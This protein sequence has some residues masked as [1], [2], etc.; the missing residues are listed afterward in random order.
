MG[1]AVGAEMTTGASVARGGLWLMLSN[2]LPQ[3]YALVLSIA[4]ARYLGPSGMGRQSFIAFVE[5]ATAEILSSGLAVSLM[6]FVG[7][8]V[9]AGGTGQARW[10]ASRILRVQAGGALIGGGAL[11][12]LGLL[13]HRPQAA[14]ILAGVTTAAA[15]VAAVPGAVLTGLQRWR[16]ATVAGLTT[17]GLGTAATVLVLALGGGIT[18]M[19]A[20][21]AAAGLIALVWT[22]AL[23]RGALTGIGKPSVSAPDLRR[24]A[25]RYAAFVSAGQL[26]NL[27]VWRRSEFFFLDHYSPDRQIAFYS[28][29][30]G[31]VTALVRL[32]SAMG[33]VLAPAVATLFGAGAH[34]RIR[35]GFSRALRLLLLL[36]MPLAAA[37]AAVGP[38]TLRVIWGADYGPTTRPF[39]IM[40]AASL[41]T[42]LTVLGSSLITG[43]GRV[44]LPLLADTGAAAVDIGLAFA[45]VPRHGAVGAAIA[46]LAA[47]V[48][49]G[50]PLIAYSWR[51]AG[52]IRWEARVLMRAAALAAIGGAVAWLVVD[53]L[54]GAA[55]IVLGLV[56]GG[57]A[58]LALAALFG[59]LARDDAEWLAEVIGPRGS[60]VL[61]RLVL[62]LAGR[63]TPRGRLS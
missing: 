5:L 4:A 22:A 41:V 55:G 19:F 27:I 30:F 15:V 14:W 1:P 20:V 45:L 57:A 50:V 62:V 40:V 43:L 47:Q 61:G 10:L 54:G 53:A 24:R 46:N 11:V 31:V 7:E 37:A 13:G 21:E 42:P 51:I 58:F 32:P 34:E 44:W 9:G 25:L 26:L 52:P 23:A 48:T 6:R 8:S 59:I 17:G 49:A 38:E 63:G 33:K 18:G 16:Y 12:A 29:A 2:A 28:I 36:T 56:G 60:G 3:L 39:L 35:T